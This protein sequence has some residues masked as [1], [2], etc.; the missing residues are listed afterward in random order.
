MANFDAPTI[1][2]VSVV[3]SII[4][5]TAPAEEAIVG[6]RYVRLNTTSGTV[7]YGNGTSAAEARRGG[8]AIASAAAGQ[9]VTVLVLG[10]IDL[11]SIFSAAAYDSSVF[12][13]DTD[14]RLANGDDGTVMR[15]VGKVVPGW[16][17]QTADILLFVNGV[18]GLETAV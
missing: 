15:Y 5:Y 8:I 18:A 10:T 12:L 11:G 6:G 7:E 3:E 13:S 4:Q 1:G 17:N 14:G 2:L 9:A 16:G